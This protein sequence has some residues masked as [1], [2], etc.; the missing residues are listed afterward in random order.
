MAGRQMAKMPGQTLGSNGDFPALSL[1]PSVTHELSFP[2]RQSRILR[3]PEIQLN[4]LV[5]KSEPRR[6]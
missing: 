1:R 4:T 2:W 6:M 5:F 3:N